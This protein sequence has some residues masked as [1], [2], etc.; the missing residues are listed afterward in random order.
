MKKLIYTILFST[1]SL[2]A[3]AG[4]KSSELSISLFD[5]SPFVVMFDNGWFGQPTNMFNISNVHP[6]KH[7]LKI[8]RYAYLPGCW[9]PVQQ[10]VFSGCIQ[11]PAKSKVCAMITSCGK[12]DVVSITPLWGH[13]GGWGHT[14]GNSCGNG[15]DGYGGGGWDNY[16]GGYGW[17]YMPGMSPQAFNQLKMAIT[18][19]SFDSSKLQVAKQAIGSNYL[20]AG[21]VSELMELLTF[22]SS[23]LE[24]AKFAYNRT[25]DKQNYYLVNNAFQ[26][27]SSVWE[28]NQY[29]K[30]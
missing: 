9:T 7:E 25:I 24:L 4:H 29:I 19:K 10:T 8:I 14:C 6:G 20:T 21:Q 16:G 23:R 3:S 2:A 13:G 27:E 15:C 18:S 5:N 22:E 26:F 30:S 11:V 12:Y 28:L 1:V 17:G